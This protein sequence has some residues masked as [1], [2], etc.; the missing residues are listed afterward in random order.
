MNQADYQKL[1]PIVQAGAEGKTIQWR[2]DCATGWVEPSQVHRTGEYRIKPETIKYRIAL[3]HNYYTNKLYTVS[4][5]DSYKEVESQP[6]FA[7]WIGEE[8]EVEI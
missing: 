7:R 3:M 8:Q 6:T 2:H 5:S 1:L 4:I